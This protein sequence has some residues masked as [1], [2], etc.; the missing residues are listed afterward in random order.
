LQSRSSRVRRDVPEKHGKY[1]VILSKEAGLLDQSLGYQYRHGEALSPG[2]STPERAKYAETILCGRLEAALQRCN[3]SLSTT[4]IDD[5]LRRITHYAG[6]SLIESN[7]ELYHWI[8]NGVPV[9][10]DSDG[11]TRRQLVQVVNW[12]DPAQNDW[13][14]V[15]QFTVKGK[16]TDRPDLVVF[17]N[18]LPISIIE[19]KNPADESADV[20]KALN[21]IK[22]Y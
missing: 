22:N 19:L 5:A 17:L 16:K 1:D 4:A 2:G 10:V 20:S 18:G 8:R 21:Q 15:N 12:V 14:V 11:H 9:D 6:T 13:L 7:R 3:P